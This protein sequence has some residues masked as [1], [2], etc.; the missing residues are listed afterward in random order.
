MKKTSTVRVNGNVIFKGHKLTIGMDLGDCWSYYCVLDEAGKIILEQK[1]ATTAEAMK[2]TFERIPRSLIAMETGTH[3]PWVSRLPECAFALRLP[4]RPRQLGIDSRQPCQC[5]RIVSI[6][7]SIA[8]GD[9]LHFLC[10][11]HVLT[12]LGHEVLVLGTSLHFSDLG[13]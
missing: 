8:L 6:I 11:C 2:Q 7:F 3:S 10:V 9:Q 13:T 1:V 12:E 5:P 4:H